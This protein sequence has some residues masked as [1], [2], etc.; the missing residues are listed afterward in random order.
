MSEITIK[1]HPD[2]DSSR[3]D[4]VF[5]A[6]NMDAVATVSNGERTFYVIVCG[7]TKALVWPTAEA[8]NDG[9]TEATIVRSGDEWKA[10]GILTDSDLLAAD[11]RIEW[12]NNS[13]YEVRPNDSTDE[14]VFDGAVFHTVYDAVSD[15]KEH[16]EQQGEDDAC[17]TCGGTGK[18]ESTTEDSPTALV[19]LGP[20]PDCDAHQ[21]V[22]SLTDDLVA[23]F[24]LG[25]EEAG[26]DFGVTFDDSPDSL[27]SRAYDMGRS[28][29]RPDD[30]PEPVEPSAD[31]LYRINDA[32]T[33]ICDEA[34]IT[35]YDDALNDLTWTV[36]RSL[37]SNGERDDESEWSEW[38]REKS[39]REQLGEA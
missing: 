14:D 34:G 39:M 4:A 11:D 16:F 19:D 24:R 38:E 8:C 6:G 32:L 36:A 17:N 9:H 28:L 20:C 22:E 25:Y 10:V 23:A 29:G 27:R 37:T 5:Y 26:G 33:A 18:W 30:H 3:E 21:P 15:V 13:W 2:Y 12:V 31:L 7:V 35:L 1:Y